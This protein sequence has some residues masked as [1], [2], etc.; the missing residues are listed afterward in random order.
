MWAIGTIDQ[1]QTLSFKKFR[2][3]VNK[4]KDVVGKNLVMYLE[5]DNIYLSVKFLSWDQGQIGGFSYERST[6]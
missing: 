6:K 5:V 3:A 1:V 4:P 2:A